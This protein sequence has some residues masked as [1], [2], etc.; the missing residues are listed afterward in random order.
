MEKRKTPIYIV[1]ACDSRKGIGKKGKL[2]WHFPKELKYFQK[3]TTKT[4]SATKLNMV[5]MGRRTW[6]S[7]PEKH[8]PLPGRRNVI[9][10]RDEKFKADHAT[11]VHSYNDA[12]AQADEFIETIFII[13]GGKV[14]EQAMK[15]GRTKGAYVTHIQSSFDC[16]TFLSK[17]P[18]KFK[19]KK[20]G[21]DSEKDTKFEYF[22]YEKK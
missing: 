15:D 1:V 16:D 18:M 8:R 11:V 13:G 17:I 6:E 20:L 22:L 14:F 2:P 9:M 21:A 3:V 7:I 5:I 19:R 4:R 12:L 10:T